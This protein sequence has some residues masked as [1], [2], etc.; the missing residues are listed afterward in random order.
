MKIP[1]TREQ[2]QQAA[3]EKR[4]RATRLSNLGL[5]HKQIAERLGIA[6]STVAHLLHG[7]P[8]PRSMPLS[9]RKRG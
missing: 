8:A 2:Q 6:G 5:T 9:G 4:E 7:Y 1:R 3:A